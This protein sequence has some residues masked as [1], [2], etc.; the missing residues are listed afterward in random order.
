[1]SGELTETQRQITQLIAAPSANFGLVYESSYLYCC[2][3]E[4][5]LFL[6]YKQIY[7]GRA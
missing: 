5:Y 1:M 7:N 2:A 4:Y 3:N 6:L